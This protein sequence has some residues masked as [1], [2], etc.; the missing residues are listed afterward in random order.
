MHNS[1]LAGRMMH[2]MWL[3]GD[4]DAGPCAARRQ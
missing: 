2:G 3:M 4:D 1:M